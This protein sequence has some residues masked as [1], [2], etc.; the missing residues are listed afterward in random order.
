MIDRLITAGIWMC[1]AVL[2]TP[3]MAL[4]VGMLATIAHNGGLY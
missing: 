1:A 2:A 3:I 4:A